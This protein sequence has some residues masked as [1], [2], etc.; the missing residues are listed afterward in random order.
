MLLQ[1]SNISAARCSDGPYIIRVVLIRRFRT[2]L[3]QRIIAKFVRSGG[4]MYST[5]QRMFSAFP[6]VTI[7]K[8]VYTTWALVKVIGTVV[9]YVQ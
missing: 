6:I 3:K 2:H 1:V 4:T 5:S 7:V 9:T 8:T